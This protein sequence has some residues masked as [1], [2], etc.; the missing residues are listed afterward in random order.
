MSE[1]NGNGV[2]K[3]VSDDP[4]ATGIWLMTMMGDRDVLAM[5]EGSDAD[6]PTTEE[7]L[8]SEL[9]QF[10]SM[11][12]TIRRKYVLSQVRFPLPMMDANGKRVGGFHPGSID[13][14][15]KHEMCIGLAYDFPSHINLA[16][17]TFLNEFHAE[18]IER[19]RVTV[20]NADAAAEM[21]I[22]MMKSNIISPSGI[23]LR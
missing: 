14:V 10:R 20:K 17:V 12:V 15:C 1:S 4:F 8:R 23:G 22:R 6:G 13:A 16:C 5:V 2:K 11:C 9:V 18:D 21:N 7:E 3:I 19:L